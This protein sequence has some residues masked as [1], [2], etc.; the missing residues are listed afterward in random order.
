MGALTRDLITPAQAEAIAA[1]VMVYYSDHCTR[2]S[3]VLYCT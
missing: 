1:Q 2:V 3:T